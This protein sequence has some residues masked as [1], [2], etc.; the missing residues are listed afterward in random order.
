[1]TY[2]TISSEDKLQEDIQY[3]WD[4]LYWNAKK[5]G[6]DVTFNQ[7]YAQFIQKTVVALG[8]KEP[9]ELWHAYYPSRDLALM[10][11]HPMDWHCKVADVPRMDLQ[12][13]EPVF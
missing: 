6:K 4:A 2:E 12:W 13:G 3:E 8:T 1:M 11:T 10:P 7:L 9:R 5:N